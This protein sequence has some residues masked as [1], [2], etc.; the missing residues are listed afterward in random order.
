MC[1]KVE[2]LSVLPLC[3]PAEA[4]VWCVELAE[5]EN[6]GQVVEPPFRAQKTCLKAVQQDGGRRRLPG[7]HHSTQRGL[8]TPW[9]SGE[10][11][12]GLQTVCGEAWIHTALG[13]L[14]R[15]VSCG[16]GLTPEPVSWGCDTD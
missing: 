16:M 13:G 4:Q 12:S 2:T 9:L 7:S 3:S 11:R 14:V 6:K 10:A 15:R 5:Q 1:F 8:G